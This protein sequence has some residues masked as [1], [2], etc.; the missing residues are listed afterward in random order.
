MEERLIKLIY[1][2]ALRFDDLSKIKNSF[3]I[4]CLK[5]IYYHFLCLWKK[6]T[7]IY[8]FSNPQHQVV[9]FWQFRNERDAICKEIESE[10]K[11]W[12][13]IE[14][15]PRMCKGVNWRKVFWINPLF[16]IKF[17]ILSIKYVGFKSMRSFS[18]A[19]NA[20][21]LHNYLLK[22]N[23]KNI[24]SISV[25]TTNMVSPISIAINEFAQNLGLKTYYL[26]HAITPRLAFH[27]VIYSNYIVRAA[28][29]KNMMIELGIPSDII[30][31]NKNYLY[32]F[33]PKL[34]NK[35]LF[36]RIGIA[37]NDLD[38]IESIQELVF[39]L[40][41]KKLKIILRVHEADL[42]FKFFS[43]LA[44][45]LNVEIE[46]AAIKPIK[47][48]LQNIDF[49]FAGNSTVL[50]D[51]IVAGVPVCYYWLGNEEMFD[52]YGIVKETG[53]PS[54]NNIKDMNIAFQFY[55]AN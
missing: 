30:E 39:F 31:L 6:S 35:F 24:P 46:S 10:E 9:C 37:I 8:D 26:E 55:S 43:A 49:I 11:S 54:I 2:E 5:L 42:R 15:N 36:N 21:A 13:S 28:H 4:S 51:A 1:Y 14:I 27:G 53:C 48:F 44:S 45:K 38:S 52:Y 22:V 12:I 16:I 25:L 29:T 18:P 40:K 34:K 33:P 32:T 17:I 47:N 7:E 19:Y 41:Q 23:R 50:F 20:Y 3:I